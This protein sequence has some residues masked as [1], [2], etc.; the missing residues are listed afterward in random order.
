MRVH[1]T[2]YPGEPLNMNIVGPIEKSERG[3]QY[4]LCVT[5]HLFKFAKAIS[6]QRHTAAI[7]AEEFTTRWFNEYGK[8]KQ[9]Q[10]DQEAEF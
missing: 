9:I 6:L 1:V 2:G 8:P 5:D 7:V 10:T 3:N 4:L